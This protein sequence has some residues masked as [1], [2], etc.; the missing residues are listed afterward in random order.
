MHV[1][2]AMKTRD[3]PIR[4]LSFEERYKRFWVEPGC[5]RESVK[6]ILNMIEKTFVAQVDSALL[7]LQI[8]EEK[9]DNKVC[10][11]MDDAK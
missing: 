2:E 7:K 9:S 11:L 5:I 3:P 10:I 4:E 8:I 1:L 6:K